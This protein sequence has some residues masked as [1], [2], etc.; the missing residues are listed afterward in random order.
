M[1]RGIRLK[2]YKPPGGL[3]RKIL[4]EGLRLN[5]ETFGDIPLNPGTGLPFFINPDFEQP[6]SVLMPE[7]K[8]DGTHNA[9]RIQLWRPLGRA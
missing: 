3:E 2:S 5:P 4:R 1:A 9:E 8:V 7:I 6:E